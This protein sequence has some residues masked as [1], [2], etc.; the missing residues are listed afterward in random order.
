MNC[1]VCKR[2]RPLNP[3]ITGYN[4]DPH[5]GPKEITYRCICLFERTIPWPEATRREREQAFLAELSRQAANEMM[6]R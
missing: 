3:W 1:P 4:S 2:S 5:R 6:G